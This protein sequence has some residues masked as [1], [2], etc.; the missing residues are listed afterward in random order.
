MR[1]IPPL[2]VSCFLALL[3]AVLWWRSA[4]P[5]LAQ[6]GP[7]PATCRVGAYVI[8]LHDFDLDTNTFVADLWL[9]SVCPTGAQKPLQTM[10]FVNAD[11]IAVLLDS[12]LERDG[13]SWANR[14]VRG[15]F[16]HDWD[17]RNFPFERERLF[18]LLEE[19]VEDAR[20]FVYEADTANTTFDSAIHVPGWKIT[21]FALLDSHAAY[22]TT[23]GDPTLPPEAGSE[24]SRLTLQIGLERVEMAGFLKLTALAYAA[25]LFSLVTY[26]MHLETTTAISPQLGLLA[27]ALFAAAVNMVT[28][29]DALGSASELTLV[30]KIHVVV[31]VYLVLAALIAVVSRLLWGRGW[32]E[33]TLA[34]LNYLAGALA[35]VSFVAINVVLI[36]AAA[37]GG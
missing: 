27:V 35:V 28:A 1:H 31:L 33:P 4:P 5:A 37:R 8:S 25:F 17:E 9:W 36:A 13:A 24:Y 7:A 22:D 29:S 26:V 21:D 6:S 10:E 2:I 14:K 34:R 23:F 32:R 20:T 15:T 18:I 30:D 16:R 12:T 19:A 3:L 11:D